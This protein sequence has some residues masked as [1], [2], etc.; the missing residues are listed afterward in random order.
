M[1][2]EVVE[3]VVASNFQKSYSIRAEREKE[4]AM[5]PPS[6][7]DVIGRL[8]NGMEIPEITDGEVV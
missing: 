7:K 2:A 6:V 3:S 8:T 5:L 1:E 4:A